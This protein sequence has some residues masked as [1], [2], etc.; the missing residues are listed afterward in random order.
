MKRRKAFPRVIDKTIIYG[1][2]FFEYDFLEVILLEVFFQLRKHSYKYLIFHRE[3]L[4][5]DS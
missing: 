3:S 2:A 4:G 1:N 5:L